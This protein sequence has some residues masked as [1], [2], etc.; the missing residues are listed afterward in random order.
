[1]PRRLFAPL[2]AF[3]GAALVVGLAALA[4]QSL[5]A[6]LEATAAFAV[7]G[8][9][10]MVVA[11]HRCE[12]GRF[13]LP[14]LLVIAGMLIVGLVLNQ[15]LAIGLYASFGT[16]LLVY[17]IFRLLAYRRAQAPPPPSLTQLMVRPRTAS[18]HPLAGPAG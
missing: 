2:G 14:P 8:A 11:T 18:L 3:L 10:A 12:A 6:P 9:M 13:E 1:M 16:A 7:F 5:Q 15:V 17:L 4:A